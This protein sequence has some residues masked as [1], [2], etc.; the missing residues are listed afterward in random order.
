MAN[1]KK[2]TVQDL[3]DEMLARLMDINW[4]MSAKRRQQL[5]E[6]LARLIKN[7]KTF[8]ETKV[9][10]Y[11]ALVEG[12]RV[13]IAALKTTMDGILA[14]RGVNPESVGGTALQITPEQIQEGIVKMLEQRP[15][16][17]SL[18]EESP[19]DVIEIPDVGEIEEA[20]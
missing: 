15:S 6:V 3:G 14:S 11:M 5:S 9:R 2:R 16:E 7:P 13:A 19:P 20:G 17:T 1:K 12:D 10:A 8:A 4:G 18:P